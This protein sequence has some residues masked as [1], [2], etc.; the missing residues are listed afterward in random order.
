MNKVAAA[1]GCKTA[2][3]MAPADVEHQTGYRVGAVSPFDQ[4]HKIATIIQAEVLSASYVYVSGAWQGVELR[5]NPE[6]AQRATGAAVAM[7]GFRREGARR[8]SVNESTVA[9]GRD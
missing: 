2:K 3:I 6:A 4:K 9:E 8:P 7:V 1:L 5:L